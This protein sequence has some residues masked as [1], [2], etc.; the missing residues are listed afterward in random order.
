MPASTAL[1]RLTIVGVKAESTQGTWAPPAAGDVIQIVDIPKIKPT[2]DKI[3]RNVIKG[4]FGV[5]KP[6]AGMHSGTI[7]LSFEMRAAGTS[8]PNS[9]VPE[10]HELLK[11]ALGKYQ[12]AGNSAVAGGGATSTVIPVTAGHG[13]ARFVVGSVVMISGEVRFV[14]SIS[15][16]D[17]TLNQ[18]LA[19]GAPANA[20]VVYNGHSYLPATTGGDYT[21]LSV[22]IW[23]DAEVSGP[24]FR[25]VGCKISKLSV[26]GFEVGAI[27]HCEVTLDLLDHDELLGTTPASPVWE[28]QIPPVGLAGV[29]SRADAAIPMSALEFELANTISK[30][31]DLNALGGT[32]RQFIT[33]REVTGSVNP[34]VDRTN[35][36]LQTAWKN[37]TSFELF[38]VL[39]TPDGTGNSGYLTQGSAIAIYMPNV[40]FTTNEREDSDG[41]MMHKL[42][43]KAHEAAGG[44][45]DDE[46]YLGFV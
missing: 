14:V 32:V 21:S 24:E 35:V 38:F 43:Y 30:E 45:G 18:A 22:A 34:L 29:A 9:D 7:D 44:N 41:L 2:I 3:D 5:Q 12:N 46:I 6:L 37:N 8:A 4:S 25:G 42:G 1:S 27:P 23:Q 31:K 13:A 10:A 33:G 39:G 19:K 20:V 36:T 15:T 17:L 26:T 11:N 40:I 16:D 28:D